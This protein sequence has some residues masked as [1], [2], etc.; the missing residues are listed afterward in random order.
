MKHYIKD[1][2][3]KMTRMSKSDLEA[4]SSQL[5]EYGI[6]ATMYRFSPTNSMWD[7]DDPTKDEYLPVSNSVI[8]H[9][10]CVE[11]CLKLINVPRDRR[12]AAVKTIKEHLA[13][14]LREA[15]DFVDTIPVVLTNS[16]SFEKLYALKTALEAIDAI[17]EMEPIS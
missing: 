15:K 8:P 16:T 3:L 14:G 5:M 6:S 11:Y 9:E 12:L 2:A 10:H 1:I 13:L 4:L 17:V 7:E